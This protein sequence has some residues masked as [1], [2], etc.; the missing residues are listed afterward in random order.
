MLRGSLN[1][2]S[3]EDIF[4]LIS[5]SENTGELQVVRPS[6][7]GRIFFRSGRVYCA[8]SELCRETLGRVLE[9]TGALGPDELAAAEEESNSS[10]RTL[11]EVLLSSESVT[12]KKLKD[13]YR[14]QVED[15]SFE[16]LRREF[17]EFGWTTDVKAEPEVSLEI[18]V[19]DVLKACKKRATQLERIRKLIPSDH[20][21]FSVVATPP[22]SN[23]T[24]TVSVHEWRLL[25]L[26]DGSSTVADV[27]R[28]AGLNDL[29]TMQLL[30]DLVDKG[31]LEVHTN[32]QVPAESGNPASNRPYEVA[33]VCTGNRIRSPLAAAFLK[34]ALP[35]QPLAITSVGIGDSHPHP[36][37][38]E[39]I[40]A[41]AEL[42][43]DLTT[44]RSKAISETDLSGAD[45]VVGFERRHLAKALERGA[46]P[47]RTFS[48]VELV[49]LL[50]KIET[51]EDSDPAGRA[52]EAVA[53]AHD[54]RRLSD[55]VPPKV[56]IVDPMGSSASAYRNTAVRLRDL[57]RRLATGLFGVSEF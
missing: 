25:S 27:A 20:S 21:A 5:R 33:F 2:F 40:E 47:E 22:T 19:E 35:G 11:A 10:R 17:G 53:R 37:E 12:E 34:G 36:A 32:T 8:E 51:P 49:D 52:R 39:A 45:L 4:W 28:D 6:G 57:A 18:R 3:L 24:I 48:I 43:A 1:D 26:I 42:G 7:A 44:H 14:S 50:E 23:A 55:S 13:A 38:P 29:S 16:L 54:R 31:L 41:A 46:R 9:R 30:H 15:V 56:E